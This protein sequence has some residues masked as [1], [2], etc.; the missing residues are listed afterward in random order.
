MFT[1]I[2]E[3]IGIIKEIKL[4]GKSGKIQINASYV[5]E[6]CHI[7]DSIAVNG[8]CLTVVD[9]DKLSFTVD[10]S[11]ETLRRTTLGEL[12]KGA[13]VNLERSLKLNERLGGH[14]VLGHVDAVGEIVNIRNEEQSVII[15]IAVPEKLM[16]YIAEKGSI[17]VDGISLTITKLIDKA[18]E[19][20]I[21][22]H[23]KYVT[24]LGLKK[25][26]EQV[27]IEVD[28]IARYM[29]RLLN[30]QNSSTN[31]KE[32]LNMDFLEQHGFLT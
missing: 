32:K 9:F 7:G 5:L 11:T 24:T 19:V 26:S 13:K 8:A 15:R 22:P 10:V 17:C 16:R 14:L 30:Y 31:Q 27:N 29:E 20:S 4:T 12:R 28:I 25:I 18:F 6:D 3:E 1:G 21:I 2:I 23:T